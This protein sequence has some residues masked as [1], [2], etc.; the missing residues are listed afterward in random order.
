MD[1][2][3]PQLGEGADSGVV[4]S[5]LVKPGESV[6]KGQTLLEIENEKAVA[7]IP[8]PVSGVV[9]RIGVK[10]GDRVSVGQVLMAIGASD[11]GAPKSTT[12]PVPQ[13]VT[14]APTSAVTPTVDKEDETESGSPEALVPSGAAP[15][16]AP[17]I[18][19]LARE[20]GLDL[21][22]VHRQ[23]APRRPRRPHLRKLWIFQS[24][25]A[26]RGSRC[27]NCARSSAGG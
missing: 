14:K 12:D 16:A 4:V 10:A 26:F 8:A 3:L 19:R 18:R 6:N 2:Q 25:A 1:V 24:G 7:P 27:R 17:S 13:K 15:T 5:I 22:L 21:T 23:Q 9:S 20:L 11:G